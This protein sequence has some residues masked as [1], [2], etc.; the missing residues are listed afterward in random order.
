MISQSKRKLK[1]KEREVSGEEKI[2]DQFKVETIKEYGSLPMN[3]NLNSTSFDPS[4]KGVCWY[5]VRGSIPIHLLIP[6]SYFSLTPL[7]TP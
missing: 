1:I 3:C 4:D 6:F 7:R 5:R 2:Y